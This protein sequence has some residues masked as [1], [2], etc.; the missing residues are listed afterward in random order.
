MKTTRSPCRNIILA[1]C[2]VIQFFVL[3]AFGLQWHDEI[4]GLNW[5]YRISDGVIIGDGSTRAIQP[6][7]GGRLV[8]PSEIDGKPVKRIAAYAFSECQ[9]TSAEIPNTVVAI[10]DYA[11]QNCTEL[12]EIHLPKLESMGEK[13]L[14]NCKSDLKIYSEGPFEKWP[15]WKKSTRDYGCKTVIYYGVSN[16]AAWGWEYTEQEE[17]EDY[18]FY[19]IKRFQYV[20]AVCADPKSSW[21]P[22]NAYPFDEPVGGVYMYPW[23]V[24]ESAFY[25]TEGTLYEIRWAI[26]WTHQNG[27]VLEKNNFY[28]IVQKRYDALI[29]ISPEPRTVFENRMAIELFPPHE[30]VELYYTIDGSDPVSNGV[31]YVQ[32]FSIRGKTTVRAVGYYRGV[33]ATKE[34]VSH[35][36]S[37]IVDAPVIMASQESFNF[38]KNRISISC[39]TPNVEIHFTTDGTEPTALS[40]IYS[41]PFTI[42]E[43]TT[44]KAVAIG[45]PDYIDSEVVT[46]QF[47]RTW[48][49]VPTPVI[50]PGDGGVFDTV[51]GIVS[52]GCDIDG[53]TIYFTTDGSKPSRAS[54]VYCGQIE[55]DDDTTIQAFAVKDDYLDSPVVKATIYNRQPY[56]EKPVISLAGGGSSF[57]GS[58]GSVV[59]MSATDG[60]TIHYTLDGTEPN[61]H[62]PVYS[63]PVSIVSTTI[64]RA[65]ASKVGCRNSAV[66]TTTFKKQWAYGDS[67]NCPDIMF[68]SEGGDWV[69]DPNVSYDGKGSLR[70]PMNPQDGKEYS[71]STE[72]LGACM[73]S[74]WWK[75]SC[76]KDE[77]DEFYYDHAEFW[78]D[79]VLVAELDGGEDE[80]K[81][82]SYCMTDEGI[83]NLTWIY[84]KDGSGKV[85]EDCVWLDCFDV[86]TGSGS[87]LSPEISPKGVFEF[88]DYE[89]VSVSIMCA[90][91]D[92]KI[93]YTVDGTDPGRN[94]IIYNGSFLVCVPVDS[95][96]T[97]R[98]VAKRQ[99][100]DDS[101]EVETLL[102][103]RHH[104]TPVQCVEVI[105]DSCCATIFVAGRRVEVG[106]VVG[107]LPTVSREGYT[108]LGWFTEADDGMAITPDVLVWSDVTFY[109]HWEKEEEQPRHVL[110]AFDLNGSEG[111]I[112]SRS[113]LV[114]GK[115]G[116]LP[117]VIWTGHV[118]MGW[119]T[120]SLGGERI[121]DEFV[122]G[123]DM[124]CYAH[125][126]IGGVGMFEG[127][128][129][130]YVVSNEIAI[131]THGG[132]Y[133]GDLLVPRV[134]NGYPVRGIDGYAFAK[135][136]RVSSVIIRDNIES[137]GDSAFAECSM[138]S[139]VVVSS[140]PVKLGRCAFSR[141][142][143]L[144]CVRFDGGKPLCQS[145]DLFKGSSNVVCFVH[146][147][148]WGDPILDN[149]QGVK[150][151]DRGSVKWFT[152]TKNDG[153]LRIDCIECY[154]NGNWCEYDGTL[155][156]PNE[157]QG[158]LVTEIGWEAFRWMPNLLGVT[159]PENVVAIG[160]DSFYECNALRYVDLP[161]SVAKLEGRTFAGCT[162]LR[163]VVIPGGTKKVGGKVFEGCSRLEFVTI[164]DGVLDV[165]GFDSCAMKDI[166]LPSSVT[167]I[168]NRAFRGCRALELIEFSPNVIGIGDS[169][170]ESCGIH[171]VELPSKLKRIGPSAFAACP[172]EC[173][174]FPNGLKEIGERA[175]YLC[176]SL[177]SVRLD[178]THV[179]TI[180]AEAFNECKSLES[181][182]TP[183]S[184]RTCGYDIFNN[185]TSLQEVILNEGLESVSSH[186]FFSCLSLENVR[187]PNTVRGIGA[188]AFA[189]CSSLRTI[190]MPENVATVEQNAFDGCSS[191]Q[192]ISL[193]G[194]TYVGSSAFSGCALLR[195]V[196][197]SENLEHIS[198]RAFYG[199]KALTQVDIPSSVHELG[200]L[201]FGACDA[202][203]AVRFKGN[204]PKIYYNQTT[205]PFDASHSIICYVYLGTYG[206]SGNWKSNEIPP[207]WNAMPIMAI[208]QGMSVSIEIN[209]VG[210]TLEVGTEWMDLYPTFCKRYGFNLAEA[211]M[212]KSGKVDVHGNPLYVWQDYVAGTDP[213]DVSSV[214]KA[215]I[216]L[217][218]GKPKVEWEPNLNENGAVREYK[219]FGKE[220]LTD[221]AWQFPIS[222]QCK[223][224]KVEV[225]MPS[226]GQ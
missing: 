75:S 161:R 71:F 180:G 21:V 72:V 182:T 49:T 62:S 201:T 124:T 181:V 174:L 185:C 35:Y 84:V 69:N 27:G 192:E 117:E 136:D 190:H 64:V 5:T 150:V 28:P 169:A 11:F 188:S 68:K 200:T 154:Q 24:K 215:K 211:L 223:F 112:E 30:D 217:V 158:R 63:G 77:W 60:A 135:C 101:V 105:F 106:G 90:T 139:N 213:T 82:V 157:L 88:V 104:E 66:Q 111:T 8:V 46:R 43:T 225:S 26:W 184:L 81:H 102:V 55:I 186:M 140:G 221:A 73:V 146:C 197:L 165:G 70:S 164:E 127:I 87:V 95:S 163:S 220:N 137:V 159:I 103:H 118:F 36:G 38:S 148:E 52:I 204:A 216:T 166:V 100:A 175:F 22:G 113:V 189:R 93:Y 206:W 40:P 199:C 33:L 45:H 86:L 17:D 16:P 173:V 39:A 149:W 108:F 48:L 210:E 142:G 167:N 110:V 2:G 34:L 99:G 219:V 13:I 78:V 74:F 162:A 14:Y 138:L 41:V 44:L 171:N 183:S 58:F 160:S 7:W 126:R 85:G 1:L 12:E 179:E 91:P 53:V 172:L 20:G 141:C 143:S 92:A 4:T 222:D 56:A 10:D 207:T 196:T 29:G 18:D 89:N 168:G 120:E 128:E 98:A 202:L 42:D 144:R 191:L 122:V 218:D 19:Q 80:W 132:T 109:A 76:E 94:G 23:D 177:L 151:V 79:D 32:K 129:W 37:G 194:V 209:D 178:E 153:S 67:L 170:F 57:V 47:T 65:Y 25:H 152:T 133:S 131:I 15:L 224:F 114:G 198:I 50:S 123:A 208:G 145:E 115:V 9:F 203:S 214:F 6:V 119:F 134:L 59:M 31:K 226:S 51:K 96:K 187:L 125:W 155:T 3:N 193:P 116:A 121:T 212:R 130:N 83:H 176:S 97:I 54:D 205:S 156:I 195:D 147:E 61:E 107:D